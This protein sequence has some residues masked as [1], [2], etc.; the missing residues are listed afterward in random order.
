M[1]MW[2]FFMPKINDFEIKCAQVGR[3]PP[4]GSIAEGKTDAVARRGREAQSILLSVVSVSIVFYVQQFQ[5]KCVSVSSL[6]I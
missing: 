3:E 4:I 6:I 2:A 1:K 5:R